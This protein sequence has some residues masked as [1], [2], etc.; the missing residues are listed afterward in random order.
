MT[1]GH[2]KAFCTSLCSTRFGNN[3]QKKKLFTIICSNATYSL[4]YENN[5]KLQR[6][7]IRLILTFVFKVDY[8][9]MWNICYGLSDKYLHIDHLRVGTALT[10]G[11]LL[12]AWFA[13]S[14]RFRVTIR[15][16]RWPS[17]LAVIHDD[18]TPVSLSRYNLIIAAKLINF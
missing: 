18:A 2:T 10:F 17:F 8:N 4:N 5:A 11:R 7:H 14:H 16:F 6:V 9:L 13:H 3:I 1:S 15:I 12:M